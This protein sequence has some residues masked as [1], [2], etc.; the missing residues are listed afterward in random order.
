[1]SVT[2][3]RSSSTAR[4]GARAAVPFAAAGFVVAISF[5]ISARAAGMPAAAAIVMSAIVYAGAAQFAAVAILAQGGSVIAAVLAAVL[6]N[7]RYLAMGLALGPSLKGGRVRR[8]MEGQSVVDAA[9]AMAN[10]GDGRFDRHTLF[11][12]SAL[13]YVTWLSGTIIGVIAGSA[14]PDPEAL[15]IDAVFP[16]FFLALLVGELR[17][18]QASAVAVGGAIVA[19]VLGLL[20]PAGIGILAASLIALVGLRG[21]RAGAEATA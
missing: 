10:R 2:S 4:A 9:W 7:G 16:A 11:G 13:Q 17:T 20:A 6:M 8:A 18:A 3:L 5:G 21:A 15:G 1:M 12:S 19:V 14:L